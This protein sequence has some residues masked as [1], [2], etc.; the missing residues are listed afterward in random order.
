[1]KRRWITLWAF[2]LLLPLFA[3]NQLPNGKF[4]LGLAGYILG[5]AGL[6]KMVPHR[7]EPHEGGFALTFEAEL[8]ERVALY[9][10][11]TP[12]TPGVE[13]EFS[14]LAKS[15]LPK[16][17]VIV[18]EYV[19]VGGSIGSAG[20]FFP[21]FTDRWERY[22]FRYQSGDLPWGGFRIVRDHFAGGAPVSVSLADLRFGPVSGPDEA[23]NLLAA[24]EWDRMDR[25]L[26]AGEEL[27]VGCR[28]L[29]R[30]KELRRGSFTWTL[31]E[32]LYGR[33]AL[34]GEFAFE[35][36]P[37]VST[38]EFK[39]KVPAANGIYRLEGQAAGEAAINAVKFGVVPRVR[40]QKGEL[41][42][43]LGVNSTFTN[44]ARSP[45]SDGEMGF[46]ADQGLSF[47][48]SWD[49]GP[50]FVWR[51]LEPEEG[52]FRWD[53]T[54]RMVEAAERAG[55]EIL[56]VL[57]GMFFT[58]P[59]MKP[60][61]KEEPRGHAQALWLYEK[62][63]VVPCP[64]NMPQFTRAGRRTVLPAVADWERMIRAL[65]ERYRGRIRHYEVMNEPNLCLT[66]EQYLAYLK[67]AHAV[68][69]AADPENRVV[70]LSA[71]GD[72]DAHI[73]EFVRDMLQLGAARYCD[74]ISFHPYNNL[75]E[76]S[77]KSGEAV[78]EGFRRYLAETGAPD[79]PLWNTELYYLNPKSRSGSDHQ[80][81]PI[82]HPGHLI[83]R[84]LLDA[85]QG[86]R[87]SILVPGPV[88]V[89]N[90]ANDNFQG[91]S[92]SG[93][94]TTRLMPNGK[95]LANAAFAQLL[96][97]TRFSGAANLPDGIRVYQFTG[98]ARAVGALFALNAE[99]TGDPRRVELPAELRVL[100]IYGN[101]M[102]LKDNRLPA[103][104]IPVYLTAGSEAELTAALAKCRV[105]GIKREKA[106]AAYSIRVDLQ[107]SMAITPG[108]AFSGCRGSNVSYGPAEL[109][110]KAINVTGDRALTGEPQ[111]YTFSFTP[112]ES[113]TVELLL[114]GPHEKQEGKLVPLWVEYREVAAEGAAVAN[115]KFD[116]QS[117]WSSRAVKGEAPEFTA[118]G[119]RAWHEAMAVQKLRVEQG[120]T[121]TITVKAK[122]SKP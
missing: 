110:P 51:E 31:T 67:S 69:K 58:Y 73:M 94:F 75:Y 20:K 18:S 42:I 79:M 84:Y 27:T 72:F 88:M 14:F 86:L 36:K 59:D 113:G 81:G 115:G 6:L 4:E 116:G 97:G 118:G 100:D 95:Y 49:N 37:G 122:R 121:V 96:R 52:K 76:D 24:F 108:P 80:Q 99:V 104:S 41:P 53:R 111:S 40:V 83:R 1:M 48:R 56:P 120:K 71:T 101:P 91:D 45:V 57:G 82:Y 60:F 64:P 65:A 63:P 119:V 10:P 46:F 112:A 19:R 68:L 8:E 9:L 43:D 35:A 54:D 30:G 32:T 39:L 28:F 26:T 38:A 25:R 90:I 103:S 102:N 87:A 106:A 2:G 98:K 62:G 109:R 114:R 78:I 55:L 92:N 29:N 21:T 23:R 107:G 3:G 70:G 66:A 17:P 93:F 89:G 7:L 105:T 5:D 13:Y 16:L 61:G 22:T 74:A 34:R 50:P 77:R 44:A 12:M 33:E 47:I 117:H 15:S 11:E 85:S